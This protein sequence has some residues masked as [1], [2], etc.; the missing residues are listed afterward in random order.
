MELADAQQV[1]TD[2]NTAQNA[3]DKFFNELA[4]ADDYDSSSEIA[5]AIGT[6]ADGDTCYWSAVGVG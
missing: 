6:A 4:D 3:R 5:A 2:K 1:E